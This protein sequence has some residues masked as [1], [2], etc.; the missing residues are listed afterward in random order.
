MKVWDSAS[1]EEVDP[2][3]RRVLRKLDAGEL[4]PLAPPAEIVATA[5]V[6][7]ADDGE[8]PVRGRLRRALLAID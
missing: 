3:I 5:D 4:D 8:G 2:A 6:E 1:E 7:W